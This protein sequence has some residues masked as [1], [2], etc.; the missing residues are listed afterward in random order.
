LSAQT[1]NTADEKNC[2]T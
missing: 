2:S 1:F